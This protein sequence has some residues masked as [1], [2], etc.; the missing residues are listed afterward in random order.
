MPKLSDPITIR[1][2]EIKNRLAFPPMLTM[3][4]D[5]NGAPSEKTFNVHVTKAR[6]GA[7]MITYEA[8]SVEPEILSEQNVS[9]NIGKDENIPAY[10]RVAD[11]VH[12]YGAK[13]G[14]QLADGGLIGFVLAS[15]FGFELESRGPSTVDLLHLTSAYEVMVPAWPYTLKQTGAICKELTIEDIIRLEDLFAAG[16]KRAI[17]AGFDFIEI[18]SAHAT[19]HSAFLAPYSNVRTDK[20]GGS[21]EKRCTFLL[22]TMEKIRKSI[23]D[24]PPLFV[25]ISADE[26]V[27]DGLKIEETKKIAKIIENAG[28]DCIDVSIGNMIRNPKGIQIPTYFEHGAFI[29]F[30]EEIKK[31]VNVPVIGVGRIVDPRMADQFI[32][33]GKA[34]IIYMGRQLICDADTPNKYFKGQ[35]DD[36][37]YCMGC[38]QGCSTTCVYDA[39]SGQNY[40]DLNPST[41]LKKIIILGA[42]IAGMEAARVAKLRGHDVEIFEKSNKVG[43]LVPL[44][45]M[46]YKKE[47]F[48]NIVKFLKSQLNKLGV[49]IHLNK[50][51]TKDEIKDLKPDILVL[52]TGTEAKIPTNLEGK[53]NILT[54]DEAILK[55][56][57]V[58]KNVVIWGLGAYWRGGPET[59]ITLREQKYNVKALMGSNTTVASEMLIATGRRLWI[60]EYLRD[61]KIPIYTKA[62]LLDVTEKGVKFLDENKTEQFIE[63]D[64]L[65]YCGSRITNAKKLKT[66]FEEVAPKIQLIGD[67][68]R[69]RDI[70]EAMNDAQTFVRKLN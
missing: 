4:S 65:V 28:V 43:G 22:E 25:R 8:V 9:A 57:P 33:Q 63:A 12:K 23:G 17:Q 55:T 6:G 51:L 2:M 56:K 13:I 36:I 59:A 18:H 35:L 46:E 24:K 54:Q 26:L 31:V 37:K 34:D 5:A 69:P 21:T 15:L 48:L 7:G 14:M 41:D 50:E 27:P 11:E 20:Y 60:L 3:S 53:P 39:Y 70:A 30:A 42:G 47:E 32:Q 62:K 58:G 67:C 38:L 40:Q 66:Q 19:L 52:A 16:A 29:H 1:G 61:N 64:T 49:P 10:K 45:A 68:K 44:L